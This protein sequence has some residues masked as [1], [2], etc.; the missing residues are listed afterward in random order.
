MLIVGLAG[1]ALCAAVAAYFVLWHDHCGRY[2]LVNSDFACE[3]GVDARN[4]PALENDAR[5][6]AADAVAQGRALHISVYFRD[7][8]GGAGFNING[9][10]VF[11]PASLLKLP[12]VI[13][14][15]QL[16][17]D[18]SPGLRQK[19]LLYDPVAL[20]RQFAIQKQINF[21]FEGRSMEAGKEYT[22]E[23]LMRESIVYSD[24]YA[25]F[26]LLK[27]INFEYPE[28]TSHV[29]RVLQELGVIDPRTP[30]EETVTVRSYASL[31][32]VLY[33]AAYL[34]PDDSELVLSWLAESTFDEGL[35]AGL[36]KG[37]VLASKF[38]EREIG[39][40]EALYD[41]GIVYYPGTPYAL[42]IMVHGNDWQELKGIL[43]D[44]S[45]MVYHEVDKRAH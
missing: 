14:L 37:T 15:L 4:Y 42:C 10:H 30:A 28:G 44:I 33:N 26:T 3:G 12:I 7:L 1:A 22:I 9:D 2:Q 13:A 36:P 35:M 27:F 5:A 6:Y 45:R 18:E 29:E 41:C 32:R 31:F 19:K 21:N 17:Y 11:A 16:E 8:R 39:A 38:G 40:S 43:A 20:D 25:Y 34:T 24:N 23:E